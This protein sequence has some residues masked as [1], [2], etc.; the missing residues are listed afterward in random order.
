MYCKSNTKWSTVS[1]TQMFHDR[2][3]EEIFRKVQF[4]LCSGT[5]RFRYA[6]S[7]QFRG[8]DIYFIYLLFRIYLSI[9][10]KHRNKD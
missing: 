10:F 3:N 4:K 9:L 8:N 1:H 6:C 5:T 7:S 2:I